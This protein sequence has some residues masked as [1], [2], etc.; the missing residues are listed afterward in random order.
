MMPCQK[1]MSL[2]IISSLIV[3]SSLYA[4]KHLPDPEIG[5]W[6]TGPLLTPS[7]NMLTS[8][9]FNLEPYVYLSRIKG[10][11]DKHWKKQSPFKFW[12][13]FVQ[14]PI[15][16]GLNSW[17]ELSITPEVLHNR[18]HASTLRQLPSASSTQFSDLPVQFGIQILRAK[19][20]HWYPS[21]GLQI[22][23]TFP[24]G[25]YNH[26]NPLK[27]KMDVGGLGTYTT[28]LNLIAS[29]LYHLFDHHAH[30]STRYSVSYSTSTPV[31]VREFNS[32]GGGI[33][34][35]GH[36]HPGHL[37]Q[38]EIGMEYSFALHWAFAI[39]FDYVHTNK[40]PFS[41]NPGLTP[42]G[43]PAIVGY[44]SSEEFS[45]APALEYNFNGNLGL[46]AGVWFSVAGRNSFNYTTGV[47]AFNWFY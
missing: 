42:L 28:N 31:E 7:A 6:F 4:L 22:S 2:G 27:R 30:L 26:L 29:K 8:G 15:Q 34:T 38:A 41:G 23:E 40:T 16:V 39:D 24:T 45:M 37:F 47:V 35:K 17:S 44:P 25:R 1:W 43:T 5:P 11:Y 33:G 12:S 20:D 18:I 10:V 14:L 13:T 3:T 9:H 21:I 19:P 36:V 32:Y 46:I